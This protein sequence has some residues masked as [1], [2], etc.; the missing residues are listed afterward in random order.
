VAVQL[1]RG[2]LSMLACSWRDSR[3]QWMQSLSA[4]FTGAQMPWSCGG[5]DGQD[6]IRW[7]ECY[8]LVTSTW[9]S[10]RDMQ[11]QAVVPETPDISTCI[12]AG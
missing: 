9:K 2:E 4:T 10:M 8:M 12:N 7:D 5:C 3:S 1:W 11:H 6:S